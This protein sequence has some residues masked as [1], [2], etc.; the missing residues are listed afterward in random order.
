MQEPSGAPDLSEHQQW[1]DSAAQRLNENL[2]ETVKDR[3]K[4]GREVEALGQSLLSERARADR[5][6]R[7]IETIERERNEWQQ[8]YEVASTGHAN[9]QSMMMEELGRLGRRLERAKAALKRDPPDAAAALAQLTQIEPNAG[10]KELAE[11]YRG[12]HGPEGIQ[13]KI[14]RTIV[15]LTPTEAEERNLRTR[16]S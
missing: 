3:A 5:Y 14:E 7:S 13:A 15:D 12:E 6:F 9:A 2:I 11:K 10:L 8:A 4:L 1:Q 16:R